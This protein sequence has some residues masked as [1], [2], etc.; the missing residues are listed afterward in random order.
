MVLLYC[1][2]LCIYLQ[3]DGSAILFQANHD[4]ALLHRTSNLSRS[5]EVVCLTYLII[6]KLFRHCRRKEQLC[7]EENQA[8]CIYETH[9]PTVRNPRKAFVN[10]KQFC[11]NLLDAGC[12][13]VPRSTESLP[14]CRSSS[15]P[16]KVK[17]RN[18]LVTNT[19]IIVLYSLRYEA[20][21]RL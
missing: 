16:C 13:T 10:C 15:Q 18:N 8:I 7:K 6:R 4:R 5:L 9:T 19:C 20:S 21:D 3:C 14:I 11:H 2:I 12:S 1:H 17:C